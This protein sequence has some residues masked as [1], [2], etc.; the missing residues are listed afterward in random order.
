MTAAGALDAYAV[1]AVVAC[2]LVAVVQ[3]LAQLR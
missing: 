1:P 3:G 2:W